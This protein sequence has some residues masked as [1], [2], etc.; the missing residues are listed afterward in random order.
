MSKFPFDF[1][2]M[3]EVEEYALHKVDIQYFRENPIG[4]YCG[5]NN[6]CMTNELVLEW[7]EFFTTGEFFVA[8]GLEGFEYD[9]EECGPVRCIQT[10]YVR[11]KDDVVIPPSYR[12]RMEQHHSRR[13][14][15]SDLDRIGLL[16]TLSSYF[17]TLVMEAGGSLCDQGGDIEDWIMYDTE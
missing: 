17:E 1:A 10:L 2:T 11:F 13:Y 3:E 5:R 16:H 12:E 6:L 4:T 15:N 8:Y 14:K 7:L 9:P